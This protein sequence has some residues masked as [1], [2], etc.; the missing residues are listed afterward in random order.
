M[1]NCASL[2]GPSRFEIQYQGRFAVKHLRITLVELPATVD[3]RLDGRMARDI[4]SL[5]RFPARG[6]PLLEAICLQ[7]GYRNTVTLDPQYNRLPGRLDSGDWRRMAET[8]VL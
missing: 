2:K 4:Y 1:L 7:T 8:D 6:V 5:L 3:G